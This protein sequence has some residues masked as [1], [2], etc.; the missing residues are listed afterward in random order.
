MSRYAG[1]RRYQQHQA[2]LADA[3]G[4][5]RSVL[6]RPLRAEWEGG[7]LRYTQAVN[8]PIQSSAADVMLVAMAKVER[9]LPGAMILQIHDELVLEVPADAADAAADSLAACMA[10]AFSDVFPDAP[11]LGLVDVATRPCWAKP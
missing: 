3:A 6:G 8:F 2:D 9:A 7:R 11:V 5:V 10:E 1:V 4:V